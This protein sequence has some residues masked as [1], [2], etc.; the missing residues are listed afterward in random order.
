MLNLI[1][2]VPAPEGAPGLIVTVEHTDGT[3]DAWK[4]LGIVLALDLPP[5]TDT[6][7]R[8]KPK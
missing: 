2:I 4:A 7:L 6:A 3:S 8:A 1:R 5:V